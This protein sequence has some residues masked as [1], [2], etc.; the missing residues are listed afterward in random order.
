[1]SAA[2]PSTVILRLDRRTGLHPAQGWAQGGPLPGVSASGQRSS[3]QAGGR[4]SASGRREGARDRR[5]GDHLG[6]QAV[7]VA[8]PSAVMAGFIPAIHG[9]FGNTGVRVDARDKPGHD[10]RESE[11]RNRSRPQRYALGREPRP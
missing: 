9:F 1:M 7:I 2:T 11:V 5:V 10:A 8:F 6:G 3:C 4:Q